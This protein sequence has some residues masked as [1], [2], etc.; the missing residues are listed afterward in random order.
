MNFLKAKEN[1][2]EI[3]GMDVDLELGIYTE[4]AQRKTHLLVTVSSY[5]EQITS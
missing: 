4:T 1:D 5:E 3:L 2:V